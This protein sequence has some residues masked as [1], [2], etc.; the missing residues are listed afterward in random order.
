MSGNVILVIPNDSQNN[1]YL[2]NTGE[3]A[4]IQ[5]TIKE[6][7]M[8]VYP[9][10]DWRDYNWKPIEKDV[11]Q[12]N[13]AAEFDRSEKSLDVN[14]PKKKLSEEKFKEQENIPLREKTNFT[15][16]TK[17]T[18]HEEEES[19]KENMNYRNTKQQSFKEDV[20]TKLLRLQTVTRDLI[21]MHSNES[22]EPTEKQRM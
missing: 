17:V 7:P 20:L 4:P 10:P 8:T 5:K 14:I 2:L 1:I 19:V 12:Q 11:E 22:S 21:R 18:N 3:I 16:H 6:N 15:K 13:N 9:W